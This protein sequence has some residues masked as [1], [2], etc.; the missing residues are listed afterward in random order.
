MR[1][2]QSILLF[3]AFFATTILAD[4]YARD[5]SDIGLAARDVWDNDGLFAREDDLYARDWEEHKNHPLVR[6]L[7]NLLAARGR[8]C[9]NN[10]EKLTEAVKKCE[11]A[12]SV[13][14]L[15]AHQ[16]ANRGG[17]YYYCHDSTGE[18]CM[19]VKTAIGLEHGECF[20]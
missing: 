1:T 11:P 18:G 6:E 9:Y 7:V 16:C 8:T 13:G 10:G 12:N 15:A 2:I 4:Y 3:L 14:M 20:V 17:K 19:K 5:D